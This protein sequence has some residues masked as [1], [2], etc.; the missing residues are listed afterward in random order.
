MFFPFYATLP[1]KLTM[2]K[3]EGDL[4]PDSKESDLFFNLKILVCS[5]L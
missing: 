2:P 3:S 5:F 1:Q 4:G